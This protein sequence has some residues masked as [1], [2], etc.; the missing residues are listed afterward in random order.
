MNTC[1]HEVLSLAPAAKSRL[2]CRHCHLTITEDELGSDCCPEC[3]EVHKIRRRD[4]ERVPADDSSLVRY[5]CE[6]CGLVIEC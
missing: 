2:R 3:L 6:G 1:S 4:F 5:C